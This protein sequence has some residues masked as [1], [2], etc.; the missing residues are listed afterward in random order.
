VGSWLT[1]VSIPNRRAISDALGGQIGSDGACKV[2]RD[3]DEDVDGLSLC[4]SLS[5]KFTAAPRLGWKIYTV[6]AMGSLRG[7]T[8]AYSICGE[9]GTEASLMFLKVQSSNAISQPASST[10]RI[11]SHAGNPSGEF[12]RE[13]SFIPEKCI[14]RHCY[15]RQR[16]CL[17]GVARN[18]D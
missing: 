17:S 18:D 12:L 6:V 4:L 15:P 14:R 8:V 11:K 9:Y 7:I 16:V 1:H 2:Q 3:C 10:S 13:Q 5:L